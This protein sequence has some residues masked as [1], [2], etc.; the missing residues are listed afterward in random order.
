VNVHVLTMIDRTGRHDLLAAA[1]REAAEKLVEDH[2]RENWAQL[3]ADSDEVSEDPDEYESDLV[4]VYMEHSGESYSIEEV[5]VHGAEVIAAAALKSRFRWLGTD[6]QANGGDAVE[7]ITEWYGKLTS[8]GN[9]C[10][11]GESIPVT[12]STCGACVASGC[13]C[14]RGTGKH[15]PNCSLWNAHVDNYEMEGSAR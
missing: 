6:E 1:T 2:V 10:L 5:G 11:C 9:V 7:A 4:D 12:H 8:G 14:G 15:H 3:A 13:T